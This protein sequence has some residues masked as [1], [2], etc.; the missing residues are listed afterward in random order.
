[1][2]HNNVKITKN[3]KKR[4]IALNC[5]AL[6]L[7]LTAGNLT[8]SGVK[9]YAET[10]VES[11]QRSQYEDKFEQIEYEIN[12]AAST[13][14]TND[15]NNVIKREEDKLKKWDDALNEI[16]NVIIK[17]LSEDEK[18]KLVQDEIDWIKDK[19][20]QASDARMSADDEMTASVYY[21]SKLA[22]LTRDR[23]HYLL[24]N[25]MKV[26]NENTQ[27]EDKQP[28]TQTTTEPITNTTTEINKE[29]EKETQTSETIDY[30]MSNK[31]KI[32][33]N[34]EHK[35]IDKFIAKLENK[36]YEDM[37]LVEDGL[38]GILTAKFK[39]TITPGDYKYKGELKNNR[40]HGMGFM[41]NKTK[42][43]Y[44]IGSFKNGQFNGFGIL[45]YEDEFNTKPHVYE[46]YFKNGK[47]SGK[48]NISYDI[49]LNLY[50]LM[51]GDTNDINI[52]DIFSF[53][54]VLYSCGNFKK[55]KLNGQGTFYSSS[56]IVEIEGRFKNNLLDGKGKM[57]SD[58]GQL[59]YE[60]NFKSGNMHGKGT[61]YN[62]DGSIKYKGKWKNG[63]VV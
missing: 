46:G 20:N 47:F 31:N 14:D 63:D 16:Y 42:N 24:N 58:E 15:L 2:K 30:E 10:Y 5:I 34:S 26:S 27:I 56:G 1:M 50:S 11:S 18:S 45:V 35:K 22:E 41:L 6:S 4:W 37:Y 8:Y 59:I 17:N 9:A 19:D 62:L 52:K 7:C 57:Y 61:L 3:K 55:G 60:G 23:C 43:Y 39:Q 28:E 44:Y 29:L 38:I 40:P 54:T 21:Y 49:E 53:D 33:F 36:E 51:L 25:Y 12:S 48:G 32:K 13:Y